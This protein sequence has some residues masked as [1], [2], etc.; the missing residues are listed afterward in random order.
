LATTIA[1]IYREGSDDVVCQICQEACARAHSALESD[2]WKIDYLKHHISQKIHLH[3]VTKLRYQKSGG[4][5]TIQ[6]LRHE[7]VPLIKHTFRHTLKKLEGTLVY[8]T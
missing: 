1:Y 4:L 2:V 5:K 3:V 7:N 8:K 6:V